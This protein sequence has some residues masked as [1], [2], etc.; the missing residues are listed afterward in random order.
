M[1]GMESDR[2][3]EGEGE[4]EAE[5]M[6]W[7]RL[8]NYRIMRE[9]GEGG[10][11]VVYAAEQLRPVRR[12]VAVKVIKPGMDT[13]GVIAHFAKERQ[14]L[15]VM[16]HPG[17][18][19]VF[20]AGA[21]EA[22]R[23]YFAMELVAGAPVT[24][25]CDRKRL[26]VRERIEIV[27]QICEAVQHAHQKGIIHRD[28][29]PGNVLIT[30]HDGKALPKIID[31]G[32][33]KAIGGEQLEDGTIFTAFEPFLGTPAY[34]SP[35]Q[36]DMGVTDIDTRSDI[37]SLG[38]M[39]YELLTGRTPLAAGPGASADETRRRIRTEMPMAP[40]AMVRGLGEAEEIAERRGME[41]GRLARA[42]RGDVDSVTMKALEKDR[43]RRYGTAGGLAAD[44]RRCLNAEPV[45]ARRQSRMYRA[46]QFARRNRTAVGAA[47]VILAAVVAAAIVSTV[48]AVRARQ[49][50]QRALIE[51]KKTEETAQFLEYAFQSITPEAAKGHDTTLLRSILDEADKHIRTGLTQDPAVEAH[52]LRIIGWSYW[53][54]AETAK[55]E[56][57]LNE[58]VRL[59]REQPGDKLE[60]FAALNWLANVESSHDIAKAEGTAREAY[61]AQTALAGSLDPH[62]EEARELATYGVALGRVLSDRGK[63]DE[64][65]AIQLKWLE[66]QRAA[67]GETSEA[68]ANTLNSLGVAE[69]TRDKPNLAAA[70]KYF[71]EVVEIRKNVDGEDSLGMARALMHLGGLLV[72]K[73]DFAGAE[74]CDEEAYATAKKYL[75]EGH[76]DLMGFKG[77]LAGVRVREN[78]ADEAEAVV[79]SAV[80]AATKPG[81]LVSG[82]S[83]RGLQAQATGLAERFEERGEKAKA[84]EW[85]Q[86]AARL[87]AM[88][89]GDK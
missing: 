4:E 22:G 8:A 31:F 5:G 72:R 44:L 70:E 30:E 78:W 6:G 68:V 16:D 1:L 29:K 32:I 36:A 3:D 42:L 50:E 53:K 86:V 65:I 28:L 11:G 57:D 71:R 83:L 73:G 49:A 56:A 69:V 26:G 18:A 77:A 15:A 37:Y 2:A 14:A 74:A 13:R 9:L 85:R 41:R 51:A 76:P 21:T 84:D 38:V 67:L 55:S 79:R 40:S 46:W 81:A 7:P 59:F 87:G 39:L 12:E 25:Y 52:L 19:R 54:I 17:I 62:S 80:E 63:H 33:A 58:A 47:G 60:L 43:A 24:K 89:E 23:A 64:G 20:D 34:M 27:I 66:F 48:A 61:A 45:N 10:F 82:R 75:P 35:E 88:G